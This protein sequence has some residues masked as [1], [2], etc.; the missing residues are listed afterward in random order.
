MGV[1]KD[2]DT[3]SIIFQL[4]DRGL[5]GEQIDRAMRQLVGND[6]RDVKTSEWHARLKRQDYVLENDKE[7]SINDLEALINGRNKLDE[8]SRQRFF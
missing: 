1:L 7:L 2:L 8:L 5:T 4:M 3:L 6:W